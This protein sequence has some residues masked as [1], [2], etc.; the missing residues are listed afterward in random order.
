MIPQIQRL[1]QD[2][3]RQWHRRPS[4][5]QRQ[6]RQAIHIPLRSKQPSHHPVVP[7]QRQHRQRQHRRRQHQRRKTQQMSELPPPI[8]MV[9]FPMSTPPRHQRGQHR[10]RHRKHQRVPQ[11]HD[12]TRHRPQQR[13]LLLHPKQRLG[14]RKK[15][16]D[17]QPRRPQRAP[18]T[19]RHGRTLDAN[20]ATKSSVAAASR[21]DDDTNRTSGGNIN[22][23]S[24][25]MSVRVGS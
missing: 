21:T 12:V 15:Q 19:H 7:P 1:P 13:L 25:S 24:A 5:R 18:P 11:H 17:G 23:A 9:P 3:I 6:T 8:V 14:Q 2:H 20:R 10:H 4:R 22:R 16:H